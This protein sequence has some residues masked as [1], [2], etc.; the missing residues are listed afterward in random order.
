[1]PEQNNSSTL[2]PGSS[3]FVVVPSNKF[4]SEQQ[5]Q[6]YNATIQSRVEKHAGNCI[7]TEHNNFVAYFNEVANAVNCAINILETFNNYN[8]KSETIKTISVQIG[9]HY[10]ELFVSENIPQGEVVDVAKDIAQITPE[11]KIYISREVYN[12]ARVKLLVQMTSIGEHILPTTQIPKIIFNVDW[13]LVEI[14]LAESLRKIPR[15][16]IGQK[17]KREVYEPRKEQNKITILLVFGIII[18]ILLYM[19]YQ[20]WL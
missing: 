14:N 2:I 11:N 12:R 3:V 10:G 6:F 1:M 8:E 16:T 5:I 7:T 17:V 20:K 4:V 15:E 19:R 9:L 13:K 18:A